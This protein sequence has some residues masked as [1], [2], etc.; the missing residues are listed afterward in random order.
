MQPPWVPP[1]PQ[2]MQSWPALL[3]PQATAAAPPPG[4]MHLPSSSNTNPS[5]TPMGSKR[6]DDRRPHEVD[7]ISTPVGKR[8]RPTVKQ[9]QGW[10][11]FDEDGFRLA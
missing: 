6:E 4:G 2:H 8:Q 10:G 11:P 1:P 5:P 3:F 7:D 9:E